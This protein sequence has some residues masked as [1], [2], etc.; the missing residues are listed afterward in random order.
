MCFAS[1]VAQ[2]SEEGRRARPACLHP[3]LETQFRLFMSHSLSRNEGTR[4]GPSTG[5]ECLGFDGFPWRL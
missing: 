2:G 5:G 1:A 3:E 4:C